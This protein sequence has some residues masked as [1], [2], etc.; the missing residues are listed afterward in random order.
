VIN[1]G[2]ISFSREYEIFWG[3]N[4]R[5]ITIRKTIPDIMSTNKIIMS[6]IT[7]I[8]WKNGNMNR[9]IV[10]G[11]AQT[12]FF[13]NRFFRIRNNA[14]GKNRFDSRF[15]VKLKYHPTQKEQQ[16]TSPMTTASQGT[17]TVSNI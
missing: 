9:T 8:G 4:F 17:S 10:M 7:G 6:A 3:K 12:H 5:N 16:I 1:R 15:G 13:A 2:V 14:R 11:I